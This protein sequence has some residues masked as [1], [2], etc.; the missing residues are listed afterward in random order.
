MWFIENSSIGLYLVM[1][2]IKRTNT[3]ILTIKIL[4]YEYLKSGSIS[5]NYISTMNKLTKR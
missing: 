5:L 1:M 2:E 3:V 4:Y